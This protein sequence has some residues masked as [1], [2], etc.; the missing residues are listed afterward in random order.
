MNP[1]PNQ[2]PNQKLTLF[3]FHIRRGFVVAFALV[4]SL[5]VGAGLERWV[6]R[7]GIPANSASDFQ[8]MAQA[9]Q[10]IDRYYV[11]RPAIRHSAM[12]AGA[13][14]GMTEALGDTGH[15][16]YLTAPE[17]RKAGAAVQGKMNGIGVE[18]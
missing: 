6:L 7:T 8:L 1:S 11:D 12:T 14:N 17:A 15:S 10:I 4:M 3:S 2:S 13:I 9:W 16:V 18:I 5:S